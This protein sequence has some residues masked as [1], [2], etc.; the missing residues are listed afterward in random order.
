MVFEATSPKEGPLLWRDNLRSYFRLF[1]A[2]ANVANI[3]PSQALYVESMRQNLTAYHHW[4]INPE[5]EG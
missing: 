5:D 4:N 2:E 3:M 1:G